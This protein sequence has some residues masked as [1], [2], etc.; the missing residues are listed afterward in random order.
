MVQCISYAKRA[1]QFEGMTAIF[2][3]DGW[4][5]KT[6]IGLAFSGILRRDRYREDLAK[7]LLVGEGNLL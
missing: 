2:T 5:L 1:N 4:K 7:G 6:A 3:A